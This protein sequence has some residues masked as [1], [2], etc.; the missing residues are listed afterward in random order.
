M[1]FLPARGDGAEVAGIALASEG[2]PRRFP[3]WSDL[4]DDC[5]F[6]P[7]RSA[8]RGTDLTDVQRSQRVSLR[9]TV[10]EVISGAMR[11]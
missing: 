11:E 10:V 3:A 1:A 2:V 6:P 5:D 4:P 9:C 8:V 7:E